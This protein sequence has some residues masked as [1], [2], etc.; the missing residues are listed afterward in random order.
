MSVVVDTV[1]LYYFFSRFVRYLPP[2]WVSAKSQ[3]F[4]ASRDAFRLPGFPLNLKKKKILAKIAKIQK[5]HFKT[6]SKSLKIMKIV[7]KLE[8]L[9][10]IKTKIEKIKKQRSKAKTESEKHK[11]ITKIQKERD[12]KN[13]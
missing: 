5:E 7:E 10:K 6:V 13:T 3:N 2:S 11:Q 9:K 4:R 1:S 12:K 8:N